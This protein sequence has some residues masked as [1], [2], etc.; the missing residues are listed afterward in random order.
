MQKDE[1]KLSLREIFALSS[2]SSNFIYE[3]F[4]RTIFMTP[5]TIKRFSA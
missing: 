5:A 2:S 3:D 1:V 4:A